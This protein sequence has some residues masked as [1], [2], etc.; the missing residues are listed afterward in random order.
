MSCQFRYVIEP[1]PQTVSLRLFYDEDGTPRAE[2]VGPIDALQTGAD[3]C[4]VNCNVA[5]TAAIRIA[6]CNDV[7]IVVLGDL[8]LWDPGWGQV[9]A[10][11]TLPPSIRNKAMLDTPVSCGSSIRPN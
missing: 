9:T 2:V 4:L 6:N 1:E 8:G 11:V 10:C 5:L 3:R 7:E